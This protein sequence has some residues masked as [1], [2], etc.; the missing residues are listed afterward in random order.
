MKLPARHEAEDAMEKKKCQKTS[1]EGQWLRKWRTPGPSSLHNGSP[2]GCPKRHLDLNIYNV[3]IWIYFL[4]LTSIKLLGFPMSSFNKRCFCWFPISTPSFPCP[5]PTVD[6]S[7]L[8]A[9][10][11]A[12]TSPVSHCVPVPF[13]LLL[14]SL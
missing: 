4:F 13:F 10:L 5:C 12:F 2:L 14:W 3:L 6:P 9:H 11:S 8:C 1:A 7:T